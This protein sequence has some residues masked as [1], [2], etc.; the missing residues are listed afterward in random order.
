M[1]VR[2][3]IQP[4]KLFGLL[5]VPFGVLWTVWFGPF[6]VPDVATFWRVFLTTV[7]AASLVALYF[8]ENYQKRG[9]TPSAA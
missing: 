7:L 5:L 8:H 1:E 4:L 2:S 3:W 9:S 6:P